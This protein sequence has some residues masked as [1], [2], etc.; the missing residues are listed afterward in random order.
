MPSYCTS[1]IDAE[2]T[3][4]KYFLILIVYNGAI[5]PERLLGSSCTTY[6]I[7][8]KVDFRCLVRSVILLDTE[9]DK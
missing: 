1:H 3:N 5:V 7:S 6:R 8:V 4:H 9:F 2:M